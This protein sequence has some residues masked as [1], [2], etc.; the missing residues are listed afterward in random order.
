MLGTGTRPAPG[1]MA[2]P[3]VQPTLDD[4]GTP[5]AA[6]TFVVVDLETTG[7]TP[8]AAAITEI[9]AVKVRGGEVLGEFQT[10]VDPGTPIPAFIATLTGIT[11]SMVVGQPRIEEVSDLDDDSRTYPVITGD[12]R[13]VRGTWLPR[14][15]V[16]GTPV[17]KPTP[18]FTKLDDA[19]VE[20]E[21]ERL[22]QS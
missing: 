16:P 1:T 8:A 11:T 19:I 2:G 5:L 20:E 18:V 7:G 14:E 3:A 22:R 9:G 15:V 17:G 4:V 12:Y 6:V 13:S 21:L 10:L